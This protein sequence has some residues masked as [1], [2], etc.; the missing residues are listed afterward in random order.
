[1]DND[2]IIK[3]E[4]EYIKD[5]DNIK[6]NYDYHSY[7]NIINANQK[8]KQLNQ[9]KSKKDYNITLNS[10]IL[11]NKKQNELKRNSL[12][13][14]SSV[15]NTDIN[16][17]AKHDYIN[18]NENK[19]YIQTTR[20]NNNISSNALNI[21]KIDND[22]KNIIK[23]KE[24]LEK[25]LYLNDLVSDSNENNY[26]VSKIIRKKSEESKDYDTLELITKK[27]NKNKTNKNKNN[28]INKIS[29]NYIITNDELDIEDDEES[30]EYS[31]HN[32]KNLQCYKSNSQLNTGI[33]NYNILDKKGNKCTSNFIFQNKYD[34]LYKEYFNTKTKYEINKNNMNI[35]QKKLKQKNHDISQMK[36]I[37]ISNKQQIHFLSSLKDSNSKSLKDNETL[38]N[39]LKMTITNLNTKIIELKNKLSNNIQS[40][41]NYEQIKVEN[42]TLKIY[43]NDRDKTISTLKNSLAFL[44]KNLDSILH[45]PENDTNEKIIN[46]CE[47]KIKL[48]KEKMDQKMNEYNI[49]KNQNLEEKLEK[50]LINMKELNENIN[51]K[52]KEIIEIKNENDKLKKN[53]DDKNIQ[54][55]DLNIIIEQKNKEINDIQKLLLDKKISNIKELKIIKQ[56]S[57]VLY[58]QFNQ[59]KKYEIIKNKNKNKKNWDMHEILNDTNTLIFNDNSNKYE[60]E[61]TNSNLNLNTNNKIFIKK[62]KKNHSESKNKNHFNK[63]KLVKKRNNNKF[64][65][66]TNFDYF[67]DD[68]FLENEPKKIMKSL[69][70]INYRK[71]KS[72]KNFNTIIGNNLFINRTSTTNLNN[73]E[74]KIET[75]RTLKLHLYNTNDEDLKKPYYIKPYNKHNKIKKPTNNLFLSTS[76]ISLSQNEN[77]KSKT[78]PEKSTSNFDF[79]YSLVNNSDIICFN[80]KQKKFDIIKIKDNTK[81]IY[82]SYISYYRQNK[83]QPLLLNTQKYFYILMQKYIFYY[84]SSSNYI[85]ILTKAYSN[86]LNGK[87][88]QIENSLYLISGNK[89]TQCEMY[90]LIINENKLLPSTNY[91][92]INSGICN[93]NN[94]YIYIFFGQFC[95]NSIERLNIKNLNYDE[96]W[97]IIQ[98]NEF[99]GINNSIIYLDKFMTFLDD[100]NNVIIFGGQ[101]YN[102]EKSNKNIYGFNLSEKSLSIIGKIDSCAKYCNQYIKLDESIFSVFDE[103]NGLHFF[104]KELDYHEIF[105]LNL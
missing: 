15:K 27:S 10:N 45:T 88:I 58:N 104:S 43:L 61:K 4:I 54:I 76:T 78:Y 11:N 94:E 73:K 6:L 20:N 57:F 19:K 12:T 69:Y 71:N 100:Y 75:A 95:Q 40:N 82:T 9:N 92:R 86:H 16:I 52:N 84:D 64:R 13:E 65:I 36:K 17:N 53:I 21:N 96:K 72:N 23:R 34:E 85:S 48:L 105:N 89:N 67:N 98:I 7:E 47:S 38:I 2:E 29:E 99:N 59:Y 25:K 77:I 55:K 62:I 93:I 103:N 68:E 32:K 79:I 90:S 18:N 49:E 46:E 1:M 37:L 50:Y 14:I 80:L 63:D 5:T 42:E 28:N 41:A 81:G 3:E 51:K 83:L 66:K 8:L 60:N 74:S 102:N 44:T 30:I 91:P 35:L 101:D 33:D 24:S 87:F 70:N 39:N 31:N 22:Y 56:S 97:E 26:P